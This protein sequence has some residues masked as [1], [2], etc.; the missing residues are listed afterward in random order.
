MSKEAN[1]AKLIESSSTTA[2]MVGLSSISPDNKRLIVATEKLLIE[3]TAVIVNELKS[4]ILTLYRT[5]NVSLLT[6]FQ[7]KTVLSALLQYYQQ[8]PVK[9]QLNAALIKFHYYQAFICFCNNLFNQRWPGERHAMFKHFQR[10]LPPEHNEWSECIILELSCKNLA[11]A[12]LVVCMLEALLYEKFNIP[13]RSST[14]YL[15]I[16][17]KNIDNS[18]HAKMT[19]RPIDYLK[20]KGFVGFTIEDKPLEQIFSNKKNDYYD[21]CLVK[22]GIKTCTRDI[23][24]SIGQHNFQSI[25]STAQHAIS[26]PI[27]KLP[28]DFSAKLLI[29]TRTGLGSGNYINARST[30]E[31]IC[32]KLPPLTIMW[33][34]ATDGDPLPATSALPPHVTRYETDSLWKLYPLIRSLSLEADVVVSLPNYFLVDAERYLLNTPLTLSEKSILM[35]INE[36]NSSY[37]AS[38]ETTQ[39]YLDLR[40]G[41]NAGAQSLGLIK[42]TSLTL[43]TSLDEKRERLSQDEKA[44]AIFSIN[45]TAPLYFAYMYQPQKKPTCS[46]VQGLKIVD[47]LALFTQ[48]A[49]NKKHTHIK[50]ILPIDR[51]TTLNAIKAYPGIFKGCKIRYTDMSNVSKVGENEE[52]G[53]GAALYIEIFNLFPFSNLTFRQLMDYSAAHNSPVIATGDQSFIELFF[54]MTEGFMFLYQLLEHK[55][56]LFEQLK[57]IAKAENLKTLLYLL[58]NTENS[59]NTEDELTSL[60]AFLMAKQEDLKHDSMALMAVIKAQPDLVDT[61]SR[62]LVDTVLQQRHAYEIATEGEEQLSILPMSDVDALILH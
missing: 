11:E 58:T 45:P 40:S 39:K 6:P 23:F 25:I 14:K 3:P 19:Y 15:P 29:I 2:I 36:Y 18:V 53:S 22:Y 32:K 33:V 41:I 20:F 28:Q 54:T 50:A 21:Y 12:T 52:I 10:S 26:K 59:I 38:E 16:E 51:E 55:T 17:L 37:E 4:L 62:V 44:A 9:D 47:A 13:F 31:G 48:H 42:P 1:E 34:V 61:F 8:K 5:T 43:P 46:K 27:S 60:V 56:P 30:I 57:S 35:T 24:P 7:D 49:K